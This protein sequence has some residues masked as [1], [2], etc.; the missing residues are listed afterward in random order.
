VF[1]LVLAPFFVL[2]IFMRKWRSTKLI[3]SALLAFV[4]TFAVV[5]P[6]WANGRMLGGML[7][8]MTFASNLPT[9]SILSFMGTYLRQRQAS[10]ET[11]SAVR[12]AIGCL[13]VIAALIV[14]W[15]VRDFERVLAL[16]LL[17]CYTLV[18]SIQPWYLIPVIALLALKYD[19]IGFS[20][21]CLASALGLLIYL[22]DVW[23]RFGSG[24]QFA[25]RHLLGTLLLNIPIL[26]F[27]GLELMSARRRGTPPISSIPMQRNTSTHTEP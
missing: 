18:G 20:Y 12:F 17:L 13:F 15:K 1:A 8:G 5:S 9:A 14:M 2:E 27:L 11:L 23:A 21:L 16:Q 7:D 24:L 19:S 22:I 26:G 6:F 3:L 25:Q 10:P 4:V